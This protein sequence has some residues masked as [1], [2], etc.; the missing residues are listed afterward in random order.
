MRFTEEQRQKIKATMTLILH[1]LWNKK[2]ME[3]MSFIS[4]GYAEEK[5]EQV[6]RLIEGFEPFSDIVEQP[7]YTHAVTDMQQSIE[8]AH[9][10]ADEKWK[11]TFTE[12]IHI[13]AKRQA[14]FTSD[15]LVAYMRLHHPEIK[16]HDNRAAGALM[17]KAKG[18]GWCEPTEQKILSVRK[19]LH[20]PAN[21]ITVWKSLIYQPHP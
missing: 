11:N 15:D 21:K 6:V 3:K 19:E 14:T 20:H 1:D 9:K 16:T 13:I 18:E 8:R 2:W 12:T 4:Q 10:N 7:V 17:I 5:T